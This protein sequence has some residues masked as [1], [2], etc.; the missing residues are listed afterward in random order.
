MID[1]LNNLMHGFSIALQPY[2]LLLIAVGGILGTVVGMLPGLGPATGVAV[3][4]PLTF[5]MGPTAA[6]ITMTGVYIGA[7]FGGSRSSILINTPGDGAALAATFDGYPMAM[8]GRAESALAISAIASLI[9]GTIA[10]VL[11]TLLAE[12][13]AGF[14]LKF[15]PAE[16]FLLMV[17]ALSMTASMSKNNMLKGFLSMAIGLAIATIGID[18]QSGLDRFTYGSLELQTGVDFLVVIIGIY[19]MG[20]VFKSF[21]S[22]SDGTKK[23]QTKFKRIWIS[24]DDWKR[25]KWPILRSAPL[26]FIIGALP[27]AGGTMASLMCYNNEKT[28]SKHS[29]EF[30][31]GAIE[32]LAAPESANN[33]ASIGAMIPMLTLGVPGSGT[34]AVMMGALLMLGIQPG[35]LLF[36]QY[37]DTAWGLIA[38][39]FVANFILA[40]VNIPLAGVL[41]RVL[42]IPPKVL[43]PVVLG[44]AFAGCYAISSSVMDFYILTILGV[45][46]VVMKRANIPTAP[47]ILAVIVGGTMEQ[48]FRQAYRIAN[49]DLS[50]FAGSSVA[51]WLIAITILSVV[52]PLL[53]PLLK[54]RKEAKEAS[55]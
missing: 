26:G 10:A 44:L 18:A 20:E 15:G 6:L 27:G 52:L 33:A 3:L 46:G 37:P 55:A 13:V 1:I 35:P 14:A 41:V 16:Y 2:H 24:G 40:I 32:G 21:A 4:L 53:S 12:P 42:A 31:H 49:E 29:E 30:G 48:S 38:S 43:Y 50:I 11:M 7:M 23:A 36:A 54:K 8:K 34:T 28:L 51:Q 19:A 47:M 9:G 25:S 17:A 39:M 22:L 5:A 45:A